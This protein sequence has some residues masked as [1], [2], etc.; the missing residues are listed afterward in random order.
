MREST[1]VR[2]KLTFTRSAIF[3]DGESRRRSEGAG[4]GC[5]RFV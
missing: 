1:P 4:I 5:L 2:E 3:M